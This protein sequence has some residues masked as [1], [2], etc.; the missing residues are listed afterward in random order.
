MAIC[1]VGGIQALNADVLGS[2]N[3]LNLVHCVFQVRCAAGEKAD[4]FC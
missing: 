4:F 3:T 2:R 1:D